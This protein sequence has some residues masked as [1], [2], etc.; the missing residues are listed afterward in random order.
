MFLIFQITG[1]SCTLVRMNNKKNIIGIGISGDPDRVFQSVNSYK[2]SCQLLCYVTPDIS[3]PDKI[4]FKIIVS[5]NP[6]EN[7]VGDLFK[8]TIQAGIRGTL[9]S[10]RT[11]QAIKEKSG[12][13]DLERVVLLET[14]YGK[15]FFLAP[16]GIDEGWSVSQKISII[17]HAKSLCRSF[18]LPE[19]VSVLSGGRLSD[20]GRHPVVD[21]TLADAELVARMTGA[22]HEGI[23]I[24][25]AIKSSGLIIA[26]DGINGNLIFRTLL[27]LG[28]GRSH[29]APILNIGKIFVDTS[30]VNPDYHYAL[31]LATTLV[32]GSFLQN[33][34]N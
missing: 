4:S 11:L 26:P 5:E 29:G 14:S 32:E 30:R 8:N 28:N 18:D 20:I 12:V 7:L 25:D 33:S 19:S 31:N 17:E 15:K 23:L 16:V 21:R 3:I 1:A 34:I 2:G 24:E 6:E 22:V 13:R 27:F 9:P 10:E